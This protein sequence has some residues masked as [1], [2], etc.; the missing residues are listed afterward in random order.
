MHHDEQ[1]M[2]TSSF[3]AIFFP[4]FL[5]LWQPA[6]HANNQFESA[7]NSLTVKLGAREVRFGNEVAGVIVSSEVTQRGRSLLVWNGS[8]WNEDLYYVTFGQMVL[9]NKGFYRPYNYSAKAYQIN[10]SP[11][12][13]GLVKKSNQFKKRFRSATLGMLTAIQL[14]APHAPFVY[15]E[16]EKSGLVQVFRLETP[17]DLSPNIESWLKQAVFIEGKQDPQIQ[18]TYELYQT[19]SGQDPVRHVVSYKFVEAAWSAVPE[20]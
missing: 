3:I 7:P 1:H 13:W 2:K 14:D 4:L 6:L 10:V 18:L 8:A 11:D 9:Q 12:S 5:G 16:A 20:K 19:G 17:Q 15:L